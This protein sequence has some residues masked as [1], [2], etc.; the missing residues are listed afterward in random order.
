MNKIGE[1]SYQL[2]SAT[3]RDQKFQSLLFE[4]YLLKCLMADFEF[5]SLGLNCSPSGLLKFLQLKK[6]SYPLDWLQLRNFKNL[7]SILNG[8]YKD[9]FSTKNLV[10]ND[11]CSG[12]NELCRHREYGR[13]FVH[14]C[15]R[16]NLAYFN[17]CM[18]RFR[19]VTSK[20]CIFVVRIDIDKD[21]ELLCGA[22]RKMNHNDFKLIV[23]KIV[24]I[25]KQAIPSNDVTMT[26][27]KGNSNIRIFSVN[28]KTT[29]E[30]GSVIK[31]D[32]SLYNLCV[33]FLLYL[34]SVYSQVN[35]L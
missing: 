16:E 2:K 17:R 34:Q 24:A 9:L 14:H 21:Y 6:C 1:A 12:S 22:L 27:Y 15:P 33:K 32:E 23:L 26:S 7:L 25:E 3:L 5:I 30:V 4:S 28:L 20:K 19:N 29:N 10:L 8:G 13:I 18:S 35:C 31:D 11:N